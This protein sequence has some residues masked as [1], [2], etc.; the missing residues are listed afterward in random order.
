MPNN[1]CISDVVKSCIISLNTSGMINND[2][3]LCIWD[4]R[5]YEDVLEACTAYVL[6]EQ[7]KPRFHIWMKFVASTVDL[8]CFFCVNIQES[9][10][11]RLWM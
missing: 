4:L 10:D 8:L 7:S 11:C 2:L 9:V 3:N 6:G 5:S 1:I